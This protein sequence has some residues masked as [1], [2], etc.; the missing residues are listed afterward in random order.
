MQQR[1]IALKEMTGDEAQPGIDAINI[2]W[3][4]YNKESGNEIVD[5][6]LNDEAFKT[7]SDQFAREDWGKKW[8]VAIEEF[9]ELMAAFDEA[10]K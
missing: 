3:R 7:L 10:K 6:S 4:K 5:I 1:M 9:G 2:D 8:V